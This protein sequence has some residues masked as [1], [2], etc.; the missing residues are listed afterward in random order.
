LVFES[1]QKARKEQKDIK[2]KT[3]L[4]NYGIEEGGDVEPMQL[5]D[6]RTMKLFELSDYHGNRL[7]DPP[8]IWLYTYNT[9]RK[10]EPRLF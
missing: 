2:L 1:Y 7:D 8:N 10:L 6:Y 4:A 9:L 3:I 5:S